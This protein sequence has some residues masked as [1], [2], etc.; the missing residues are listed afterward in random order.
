MKKA[1]F[2]LLILTAFTCA[3]AL[4]FVYNGYL[5]TRG[6]L[7]NDIS[8]NSNSYSSIDSRLGL[9]MEFQTSAD[10]KAIW[11]VQVGKGLDGYVQWGNSAEGGGIDTRGINLQTIDAYVDYHHAAT[12]MDWKVGLQYWADHN[13]LVWD[14]DFAALITNFHATPN[15]QLE[16]GYA[17]LQEGFL[18]DSND[19]NLFLLNALLFENKAGLQ[20][21]VL[22][23]QS[24]EITSVWL[25]PYYSFKKDEF[26]ADIQAAWNFTNYH[27]QDYAEMG[28]AFSAKGKVELQSTLGFDILI[29]SGNNNKNSKSGTAFHNISEWYTNG[30]TIFG[31]GLV[32][33][34]AFV[35]WF[36]TNNN[37]HGLI[38]I[39]GNMSHQ[40]NNNMRVY[41]DLGGVSAIYQKDR[42]DDIDRQGK[43]M[44]LELNAGLKYIIAP[45]LV[46]D[47]MG[48]IGAPGNFFKVSDGSEA[49]EMLYQLVSK[50]TFIF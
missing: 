4:D 23:D 28:Y 13:S 2:L 32:H 42:F 33:E 49:N 11:K 39:V 46:L 36:G 31:R 34:D 5:A 30:L 45:E 19:T 27:D 38:S 50:L 44:G 37:D 18:D 3:S 21:L 35:G 7:F 25:M 29:T 40:L 22:V 20:D 9:A 14:D 48:A 12:N 1:L 15:L 16:L 47:T 26:S 10:L 41:A 6:A 43:F 24:N 17:K 8:H